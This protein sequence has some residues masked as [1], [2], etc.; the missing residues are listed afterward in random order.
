MSEENQEQ[1][2]DEWI[3]GLT[4]SRDAEPDEELVDAQARA[5]EPTEDVPAE[6]AQPEETQ[7]QA[8]EETEK[9][10]GKI[11]VSVLTEERNKF[12]ARIGALEGRINQLGQEN[13]R[14]QSLAEEIRALKQAK[15]SVSAQPEPDYLE[16]PKAYIDQKVGTTLDQLRN[17]QETVEQT[18]ES[19]GAQSS[20]MQQQ[21]QIQAIQRMAGSAEEAF[22]QTKSDYWE[23]L[24]YARNARNG[25]LKLAFPDGTP[26]QLAE[27]IRA[28][29]FA[30]AAQILQQG[31][32][33]AEFAYEYA[34][35]LGYTPEQAQEDP[36]VQRDIAAVRE[37]V[38]VPKT[39]AQGLGSPGASSE[40]D[41]LLNMEP[42]EFDQALKEVFN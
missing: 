4:G 25:Q 40:L 8:A 18:T 35:S 20:A 39:D 26:A 16:D 3:E 15:E 29:E 33:P 17:V 1:P 36:A 14:Y 23:A 42:D 22:A 37:S 11:P 2:Q 13:T 24:D 41:G 30:T 38:A 12:Q 19:V 7:N 27:H 5:A 21:Q 28:E 10:A 34:K 9:E 31:R 32:N 6:E